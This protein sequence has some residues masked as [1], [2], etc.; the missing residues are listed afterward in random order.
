MS[1]S[2]CGEDLM[3]ASVGVA[4][5]PGDG[6]TA[7]E[8]LARGGPE[9]VQLQDERL[10]RGTPACKTRQVCC[11]RR[12]GPRNQTGVMVHPAGSLKLH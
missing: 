12:C 11:M 5:W 2:V 7:D 8:L 10:S 4:S 9:D 6:R 1:L 3:S